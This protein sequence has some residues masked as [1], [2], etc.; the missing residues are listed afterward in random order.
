MR[1]R[2]QNDSGQWSP[3][4]SVPLQLFAFGGDV[5]QWKLQRVADLEASV[6]LSL[7]L[8]PGKWQVRIDAIDAEERAFSYIS[9]AVDLEPDSVALGTLTPFVPEV[10][11]E[12]RD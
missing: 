6:D 8:A 9:P 11:S 1:A 4:A 10:T 3:W 2:S 5:A 7:V 12:A